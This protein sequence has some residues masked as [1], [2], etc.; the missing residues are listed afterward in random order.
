MFNVRAFPRQILYFSWF[1]VLVLFLS[2]C[3]SNEGHKDHPADLDPGNVLRIDLNHNYGS[4]TPQ[5]LDC[6]GSTCVF[7]FIYSYLCVPDT[8]GELQPDLAT[9]WDYDPRTFT[10]QIRLRDDARFHNGD[11]VTAVDAADSILAISN[12]REKGLGRKI[13]FAR[14]ID[15]Y[16]LEIRLKNDDPSFLESIWDMEIFQDPGRQATPNPNDSPAGSGPF[17]LVDHTADGRVILAANENY[18]NGRPALDRVIFYYIPDREASWVRLIK[19]ETDIAGDLAVEDYKIIE[20]YADRFYFSKVLYPYYTILLYNTHHPLFENPMVRRALTHA[21]DRDYMVQTM[22]N[23]LARVTAGPMG[24]ESLWHDP[25]LNPLPYDPP[26]ALALLKKA[27]WTP[28]PQTRCL[29]KNGK[30]FEFELLLATGSETGLKLARY[31]QLCLNDIGIRVHLTALPNDKLIDR[32]F[33]NT[34]FQAVLT[35]LSTYGRRPEQ[36]LSLWV[37]MDEKRSTAGGFD[38]PEAA[39]LARLAMD[40]KDPATRQMYFQQF[41]RLIAGLAPGSFLF[42]KTYIDA[43]SKRFALKYPFSFEVYGLHR[44]QYARLKNE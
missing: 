3:S 24:N 1:L 44:L 33:Q 31:I 11:P 36:A 6:A 38:S 42:Q 28:D 22:M 17:T 43:M 27:G 7:P 8:A 29:M 12:N 16:L 18:Y 39:R 23:G 14:A 20:Q 9:A 25:D 26:L 13:K 40:A 35:S 34:A 32:Y 30:C 10:W 4:F 21:I 15:D 37:T 5:M 41:D 19:G 2:A